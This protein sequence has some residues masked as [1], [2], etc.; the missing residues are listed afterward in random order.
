MKINVIF[1]EPILLLGVNEQPGNMKKNLTKLV[2]YDFK[3]NSA[4][5][6]INL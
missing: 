3:I 2:I 1:F 4:C 6:I 5:H